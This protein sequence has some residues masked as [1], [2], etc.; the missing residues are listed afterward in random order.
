MHPVPAGRVCESLKIIGKN[1]PLSP[2][3]IHALG[4]ETPNILGCAGVCLIGLLSQ[5][6]CV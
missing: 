6:L 3:H 1:I 5:R 4:E 2:V